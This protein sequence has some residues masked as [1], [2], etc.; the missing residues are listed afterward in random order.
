AIARAPVAARQVLD[1]LLT[2]HGVEALVAP[3]TGPAWVTDVVLG[4]HYVGGGAS[5]LPAVAG[6]PHL[7]VPMGLVQGLPVG[8]SF[9]GPAWSEAELLSFGFAYESRANARTRPTY[10]PSAPR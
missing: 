8:L 7:T 2:A 10:A 1:G 9:I 4:D 3:T 6:Y 5:T